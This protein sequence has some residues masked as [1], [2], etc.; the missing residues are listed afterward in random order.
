MDTMRAKETHTTRLFAQLA[1]PL[2]VLVLCTALNVPA[3]MAAPLVLSFGSNFYGAT[4]LGTTS[5]NTGL[6]TPIDT[7]NLAGRTITQVAAGTD[8]S[9]LLADDGS[10]FSF[11]SNSGGKTGLGTDSGSTLVA[12][13]ID[14]SNL[15]GRK[16]TQLAAGYGH[17][18]LLAEDGRAFII[19]EGTLVATQIN[20][21]PLTGRKV[22]QVA[23][24]ASHSL[25][26]TDDGDV[27][28]WG[29]N[30]TGQTGQGTEIG[31]TLLPTPINTSKLGGRKIT[32]VAAGSNCSLLLAED[33][34]VFSFGWNSGGR[35]GLGRDY[36]NTL[37]AT[38]IVTTNLGGRKITQVAAGQQSLL[39]AEDGSV[40]S[41]GSNAFAQT[42]LGTD[43]GEARVATR[44]DTSN[45]GGRAITQVA[46]GQ[47]YSLLLAEDGNVFSFGWNG[48]GR[49]GMGTSLGLTLVAT[50][51][52]TSN[53]NL[54]VSQV[55]AGGGHSLIIA[56]VP[57]PGSLAL[58]G[59]ALFGLLGLLRRR[60]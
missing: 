3:T 14:A 19:G 27:F 16:I 32:Q 43:D 21:T 59:L 17:S 52:E 9:L 45:L 57:E 15:G 6:A 47:V 36:G 51:I 33:G 35:T 50:P 44:I 40:F 34:S 58:A 1:K 18:L 4:G 38:P 60:W 5:G 12:T 7:S 37:V 26:L 56:L 46:V 20:I 53:R 31:G 30:G 25:L 48:N 29:W 42:G 39:L 11:G 22:A 55:T 10:V 24:G 13:P 8:H 41:F 54:G 2:A 28:S 23:A 49:T